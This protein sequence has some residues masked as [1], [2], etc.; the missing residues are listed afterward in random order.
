MSPAASSRRRSVLVTGAS[1]GIGRAIALR[2]AREGASL[3]LTARATATLDETLAAVAAEGSLASAHA[4]D[5]GSPDSIAAIAGAIAEEPLDVVVQN[6]GA[7]RSAPFARTDDELW[8][9]M[10]AVNL[11]GPYRLARA[12][13]PGLLES[14]GAMV[15]IASTASKVGAPSVAAY[16]AAKHG[17]LGW[18]RS[19]AHE[20]A[21]KE[22]RVNAICPG[23][24][25]TSMS[26]ATLENIRAKTGKSRE[27]AEKMVDDWMASSESNR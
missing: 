24:V 9:S 20:V 15:C 14:K 8:E 4:L 19:L 22:V 3:L 26:E 2:F 18:M 16:A 6:A 10:L 23:Y 12:L 25:A 5:L 13:L 21:S 27:E 1:R 17:L 7:A 11:S